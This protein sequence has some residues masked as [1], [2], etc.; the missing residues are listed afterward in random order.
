MTCWTHLFACYVT[1]RQEPKPIVRLVRAARQGLT[2]VICKRHHGDRSRAGAPQSLRIEGCMCHTGDGLLREPLRHRNLLCEPG[3]I[4]FVY[5]L[6]VE[7]GGD[8]RC[9]EPLDDSTGPC[10]QRPASRWP[11]RGT[12]RG[13]IH[14]G[15]RRY[16]GADR[17]AQRRHC[18]TRSSSLP[19][20][21]RGRRPTASGG[22]PLIPPVVQAGALRERM[23]IDLRL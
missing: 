14:R 3:E 15:R 12:G 7:A 6:R 21:C 9:V 23:Q 5:G 20:R 8:F 19:D 16:R 1:D 4:Q 18:G 22:P 11:S 17:A 13:D 10:R 2:R